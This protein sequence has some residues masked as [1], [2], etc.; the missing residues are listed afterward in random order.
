MVANPL[1]GP[2]DRLA[3]PIGVGV[4]DSIV[5]TGEGEG[6][7]EISSYTAIVCPVIGLGIVKLAFA[8]S[9][10]QMKRV[11]RFD[12][13]G[14]FGGPGVDKGDGAVAAGGEVADRV[15]RTAGLISELPG[16]YCGRVL[17]TTYDGGDVAFK[18]CLDSGVPI[19]LETRLGCYQVSGSKDSN[20][21]VVS[22]TEVDSVDIH[23]TVVGPVVNQRNNQLTAHF[24]SSIDDLVE[25][26]QVDGGSTICPGLED[27]IGSSCTFVAVFRET[28]GDVGC[29]LVVKSPGAEDGET[30]LLASG[31]S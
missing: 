16:E 14:H 20:I 3:P 13:G 28:A 24:L 1:I 9:G 5:N 8:A 31:E 21:I 30:C 6:T 18:C 29:I 23:A 27:D 11:E 25:R 4:E 26:S 7:V 22:A 12:V 17:V 10:D 2:F 19:E 15:A